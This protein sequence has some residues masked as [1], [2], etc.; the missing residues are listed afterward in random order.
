MNDISEQR[1]SDEYW[2]RT[3]L[4][5][6][7]EAA[8]VGEVPVGA[9]LV[10]NGE[11]IGAGANAPIAKS[12][13]SAHAEILALREAAL[14]LGNYRLPGATLYATME[15]CPMCAGAIIHARLARVVYGA[16]DI[17]W[18]RGRQ[19]VRHSYLGS[20][21]S[22]SAMPR[23]ESWPIHPLRCSRRSLRRG[24]SELLAI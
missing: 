24:A 10:S 13:P 16:A 5:L 12:D 23:A 7:E 11:V 8:G 20:S 19:C 6:A 14:A 2:M 4:R 17:R 21:E 1:A 15:P 22:P 18:G 9:V 3:A